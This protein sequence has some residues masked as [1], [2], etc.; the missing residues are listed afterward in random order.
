[1]NAAISQGVAAKDIT[2]HFDSV[3][4]CL[5][6][7]L[8]AP[9]GS[10]LCGNRLF[11]DEARKWRKMAG[12]G[13]RQAGILAAAAIFALENNI[14]RLAEDHRNARRLAEGL[15]TLPALKIDY[16][17]GQ[18]NM[19]FVSMDPTQADALAVHLAEQEILI[20]P[21]ATTRLVTH[22]DI[23]ATDVETVIAAV[24]AFIKEY[25]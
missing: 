4:L 20:S 10:I 22:L 18:T 15:A 21:G 6:K 9:V 17:P 12:G 5:S 19:V 25:V 8:G 1:M 2:C 14:A 11:I 3:S 7:G 23:T 13:M 24:T 16:A